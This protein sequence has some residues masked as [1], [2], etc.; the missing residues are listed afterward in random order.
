MTPDYVDTVRL[1]RTAS[2][3]RVDARERGFARS[4]KTRQLWAQVEPP[5]TASLGPVRP[6]PHFDP[7]RFTRR[8]RTSTTSLNWAE[9]IGLAAAGAGLDIAACRHHTGAGATGLEKNR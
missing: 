1:L 5:E 4:R 3:T 6:A 7:C 9:V 2:R 8:P